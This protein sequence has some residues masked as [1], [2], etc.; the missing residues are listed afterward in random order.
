MTASKLTLSEIADA[1]GAADAERKAA[2]ARVD[3]LK[4]ELR[5]RRAECAMGTHFV[6]EVNTTTSLILDQAAVKEFLGDDLVDFQKETEVTRFAIKAI[7]AFVD[8]A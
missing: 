8:A 6:V 2:V 5:K 1:L 4:A 7:P 3:A